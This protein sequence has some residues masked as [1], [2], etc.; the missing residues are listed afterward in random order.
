MFILVNYDLG[1]VALMDSELGTRGSE[2]DASQ[3]RKRSVSD[4]EKNLLILTE[5]ERI[6]APSALARPQTRRK[7]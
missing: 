5:L 3:R 1:R 4:T 7:N 2:F 6:L